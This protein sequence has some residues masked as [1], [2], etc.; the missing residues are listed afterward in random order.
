VLTELYYIRKSEKRVVILQHCQK[1]YS[2]G[3]RCF[4]PLMLFCCFVSVAACATPDGPPAPA[5]VFGDH[6]VLQRDKPAPVWGWDKPGRKVTVSFAGQSKSAT[7]GKDGK[8]TVVLD[9]LKLNAKPQTMT[10]SG[11][12]KITLKDILV[13]D[14][15]VCSGQSNMGRNV[16]RSV[17]PKGMK[18]K[19]STIRYWGAGKSEKYP[20]DRLKLSEPKPW[21][22]CADEE[23]TRGCCAVGFF[24]ARRVQEE[25]N[26]P[27]GLL[28]QA[29]AGSIIEEWLP[30]YAWRLE[31][32][33][34]ELADKVDTCYP[35]TTHGREVWRKRLDEVE[36]W[37]ARAE[38][39]LKEG[40]PF[41][42]PQPL[43]PEPKDRGACGFYNG[44]IHPVVPLAIK[45]VLWYQGE[46]DMRNALWDV[47]LKAMA[48]SWRDLFDV[49]GKGSDIPFYWMQ[50][51]RSGGYCSPL[52][53]QEQFNALKLVPNSGMAVLLDL[54]VEVHPVN[55]VDSGI[56]LALW[57]LS[58][59]YGKKDVIPSG[60][61]YKSHRVEGAK[62][63]VEFDYT[64]GGLRI[65]AKDMLKAPVLRDSGELPNVEL[66]GKDKRWRKAVARID[67][68]KLV[69]SS[70]DVPA[71][72]H[73]RYC[74]TNIPPPPFLYNTA[75]LPA[76]MFT[77]LEK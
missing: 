47:E 41:P 3:Y 6:M 46:S 76:A 43:M 25:V 22:V 32:E 18:W 56:R 58:R 35:N 31:P 30:R 17:T 59:D 67:G 62:V 7:A 73:V 27:I 16:S 65:G 13:G 20:L 45:G 36:K 44:K 66:A 15:W 57:A 38:K 21:S 64:G 34:K 50:I 61:L 1:E 9:P 75:G 48:R 14:V 71:P 5:A 52:A 69:V 23:S 19:H 11:A 24:F 29:W 55:K 2:M 68:K 8:W 63:I 42:H 28:W 37:T 33:L 54:D 40:T 4:L 74:Y 60:P 77:T 39:S 72:L 10:I 51:Q 49:K 12:E 53:R 70:A 26:V